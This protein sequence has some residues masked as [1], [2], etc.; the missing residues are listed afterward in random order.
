MSTHEMPLDNDDHFDQMSQQHQTGLEM[1]DKIDDIRSLNSLA[2]LTTLIS[3]SPS[4]YSYFNLDKLK[5]H[6]LP[7]H[8]KLV[9]NRLLSEN[10][11]VANVQAKSSQ[12]IVRNKKEAP[13][14]DLS[15][16]IDRMKFFKVTKKATYLCDRTIEK[17]SEKPIRLETER[18]FDYDAKQLFQPF[19]KSISAKIFS[20]IDSVENLLLN[21]EMTNKQKESARLA[22]N[23][24]LMGNDDDDDA[25]I[26]D[27]FEIPC[28][29]ATNDPFFTEHGG[30]F[31]APSQ[32]TDFMMHMNNENDLN[33]VHMSQPDDPNAPQFDLIEAPLQ[34]NALN[35]EYAKTSKNID[36][37][38]L[39]AVI[40]S[41]LSNEN[42][43]VKHI[44]AFIYLFL[45]LF[46]NICL[47]ICLID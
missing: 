36:V 19:W 4:D 25:H 46:A 16:M 30:E 1:L 35:I 14:I 45:F 38:R 21:D 47:L 41:L 3:Q 26:G 15:I 42:D 29:G 34:V 17:R 7:K 37:R 32:Q 18:Q 24:A 11:N 39:K 40:W 12:A 28:T 44:S 43:K 23:N 13:R 31:G 22:P 27:D 9:A 20:D 6:D 5:L 33:H 10:K 8:L 2:E